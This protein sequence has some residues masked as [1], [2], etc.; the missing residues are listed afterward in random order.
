MN[1]PHSKKR[2]QEESPENLILK[3]IT[4]KIMIIDEAKYIKSLYGFGVRKMYNQI[5]C[6][7]FFVAI[8][9]I[10]YFVHFQ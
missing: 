3:I 9:F 5:K 10:P 8:S 7:D 1:L 4:A 6:G 2:F